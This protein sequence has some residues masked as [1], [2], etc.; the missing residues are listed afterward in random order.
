MCERSYFTEP[1]SAQKQMAQTISDIEEYV[2]DTIEILD[3]T[4]ILLKEIRSKLSKFAQPK[5]K[6]N[7]FKLQ[8]LPEK[9]KFGVDKTFDQPSEVI[10]DS[11]SFDINNDEKD[12]L[13]NFD[14]LKTIARLANK[15]VQPKLLLMNNVKEVN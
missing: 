9:T 11:K 14:N 7:S 12:E 4:E 1:I 3:A 13:N 6:R 8:F 15:L 5:I 10:N 2:D